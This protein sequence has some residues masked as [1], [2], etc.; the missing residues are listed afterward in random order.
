MIVGL[1]VRLIVGLIVGVTV[2]IPVML[3]AGWVGIASQ[4]ETIPDS[5][6]TNVATAAPTLPNLP[7][8]E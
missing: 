1:S 5:K 8:K 3:M 2:G 6:P 4:M 7:R